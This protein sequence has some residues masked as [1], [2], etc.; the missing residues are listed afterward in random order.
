MLGFAQLAFANEGCEQR[1]SECAEIGRWEVSVGL[2]LGQRSNPIIDGDDIPILVLPKISYY[3]K[4]FFL[5]N[6]TL[7]YTLLEPEGHQLNAVLTPSFDQM[8][9]NDLSLGN[10]SVGG[11]TGGEAATIANSD[12]FVADT[13]SESEESPE[14]IRDPNASSDDSAWLDGDRVSFTE[15][16]PQP[17]DDTGNPRQSEPPQVVVKDLHERSSAIFTGLEYAYYHQAWTLNVQALRDVSSVHDG[18]EIR[19]AISWSGQSAG[20]R[21][22]FSSG[23]TWQ[24]EDIVEY[25]YGVRAG[26]S[27]NDQL[28]YRGQASSSPFARVDWSRALNDRWSLQASFLTKWLGDGIS[29]SPLVEESKVTSVFF[30]GVY[31]F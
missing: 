14:P 9:F 1:D 23:F 20:N 15:D 5:E 28:F 22:G 21:F 25:Y 12:N 17:L 18:S 19:A 31:H 11:G 26:E 13:P 3:G 8:Y 16:S 24:S 10:F 2:G 7:G 4:R 29:E 30:G 6:F 27:E